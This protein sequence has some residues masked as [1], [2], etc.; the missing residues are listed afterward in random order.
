MLRLAIVKNLR[1]ISKTLATNVDQSVLVNQFSN[2]LILSSNVNNLRQFSLTA[3]RFCDSQE[4]KAEDDSD[5]KVHIL[6]KKYAGTPR[7]RTK[8]IPV[9]T[10][11]EYMKSPAFQ[12]TYGD[13]N[14]WELYRRVHKG[15]LPKSKTRKTCIRHGVIAVGSPC[16]ICRDE[17]LVLDFQNLELLKQFISPHTGEVRIFNR[18]FL[19]FS[20][21]SISKRVNLEFSFL[22]FQFQS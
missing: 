4:E 3:A 2:H 12:S 15:Q 14:V 8:I 7:D 9:E 19:S 1:F 6:Y 21:F 16:P 18:I 20:F 17:Y 5:D 10:S 13:K 11:I 22:Q